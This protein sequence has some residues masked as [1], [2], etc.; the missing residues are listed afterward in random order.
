MGQSLARALFQSSSIASR[1]LTQGVALGWNLQT[2]SAL[3]SERRAS[4]SVASA[5][6]THSSREARAMPPWL[7]PFHKC[8]R[9]EKPCG[10]ALLFSDAER[11]AANRILAG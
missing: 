7:L 8:A 11:R 4:P 9:A 1:P 3:V 6:E 5:H 2:P 10:P